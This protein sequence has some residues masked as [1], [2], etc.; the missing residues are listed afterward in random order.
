MIL[1]DIW[2]YYIWLPYNFP[3]GHLLN[4]DIEEADIIEELPLHLQLHNNDTKLQ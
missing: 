2:K 1:E 4:R 3:A